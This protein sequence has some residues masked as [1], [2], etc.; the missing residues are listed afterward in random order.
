[1]KICKTLDDT[2]ATVADF[3]SGAV[4]EV[5]EISDSYY[6]IQMITT[7]NHEERDLPNQ[8]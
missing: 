1:M 2:L 5:G 3:V 7:E 4:E 8:W 6:A